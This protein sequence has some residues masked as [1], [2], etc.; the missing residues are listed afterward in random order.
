MLRTIVR[1]GRF[2]VAK[3]T[4]RPSS[5]SRAMLIF[6]ENDQKENSKVLEE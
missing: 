1:Q 4:Y 6:V 3:A 2:G 5:Y